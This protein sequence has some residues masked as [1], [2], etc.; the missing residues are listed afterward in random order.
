MNPLI[1]K[2]SKFAAIVD[3]L[4]RKLFKQET[5]GISLLFLIFLRVN[6]NKDEA[7]DTLTHE[8]IH[9]E[10]KKETW[11]W[12]PVIYGIDYL[13]GLIR[14]KS[15]VLAKYRVRFEQEADQFENDRSYIASRSCY[16]WKS[17][18]I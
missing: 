10:Q 9:W 5:L 7:D 3:W 15:F 4:S 2:E 14:H 17:Y 13:I 11:I 12:Y 1:I 18:E 8:L 6:K 16:R